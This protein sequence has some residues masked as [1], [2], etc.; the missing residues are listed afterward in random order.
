VLDSP[1]DGQG[2]EHDREVGL[3]RVPVVVVVDRPGLQVVFGHPERLSISK[4][5]W[6]APITKSAVTGVPSGKRPGW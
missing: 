4:S 2:S 5:R 3:D 1:A 6:Q